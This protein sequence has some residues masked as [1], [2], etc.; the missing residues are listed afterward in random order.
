MANQQDA[1][2]FTVAAMR[3]DKMPCTPHVLH[4]APFHLEAKRLELRAQ[5]IGHGFHP[6]KVESAAVL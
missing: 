5:H 3:G 1:L 4:G 6:S 2:T